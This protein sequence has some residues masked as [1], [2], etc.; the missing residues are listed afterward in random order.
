MSLFISLLTKDESIDQIY[1]QQIRE[2]LL[3]LD[4]LQQLYSFS[5]I[6]LSI[7]AH[8]R[9]FAE[10]E[11][12]VLQIYTFTILLHFLKQS[13]CRIT[14]SLPF[15]LIHTFARIRCR[16]ARF[17]LVVQHG[18]CVTLIRVNSSFLPAIS[19]F[20]FTHAFNV[21]SVSF[22]FVSFIFYR[23]YYTYTHIFT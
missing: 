1:H 15:S 4:L 23:N 21:I 3:I 7:L 22:T 2:Y 18:H 9:I 5:I 12:V 6:H 13:L 20:L 17:S 11:N 19:I 16:T 10:N 8:F 14:S